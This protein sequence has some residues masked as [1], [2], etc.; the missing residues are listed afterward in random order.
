MIVALAE[1]TSAF[2]PSIQKM[3]VSWRLKKFKDHWVLGGGSTPNSSQS[4]TNSMRF[5]VGI[6]S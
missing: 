1:P 2:R 4:S 3:P 6:L 5:E